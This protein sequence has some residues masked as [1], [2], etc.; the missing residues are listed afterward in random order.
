M[1]S[2]KSEKQSWQKNL[3]DRSAPDKPGITQA[4]TVRLRS[5]DLEWLRNLPHGVSYH[6]R[7]AVTIYR[8][9]IDL[10]EP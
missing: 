1:S 9:N 8:N 4:T 3:I 6:I 10:K 2:S 5:E 7:Q